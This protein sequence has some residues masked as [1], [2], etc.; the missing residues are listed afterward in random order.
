MKLSEAKTVSSCHRLRF[1]ASYENSVRDHHHASRD[2]TEQEE[3]LLLADLFFH[4]DTTAD[5]DKDRIYRKQRIGRD[6][7]DRH[8]IAVKHDADIIRDR[9]EDA[10]RALLGEGIVGLLFRAARR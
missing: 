10:G 2:D 1:T 3:V 6:R 4:K 9:A 8:S 5:H 7:V